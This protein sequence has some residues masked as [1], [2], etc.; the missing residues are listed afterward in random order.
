MFHLGHSYS[1]CPALMASSQEPLPHGGFL[2]PLSFVVSASDPE[3]WNLRPA[4]LS[5]SQLQAV[6]I[7]VDQSG[8][9]WG[10]GKVT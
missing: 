7:F 2:S 3:S 10:A 8:I 5:S 6:G 1:N 9:T 4:Y